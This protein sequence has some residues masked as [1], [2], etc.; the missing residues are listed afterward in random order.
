MVP[1]AP[2]FPISLTIAPN[3][4]ADVKD[5]CLW[6]NKTGAVIETWTNG[7]AT[8]FWEVEN[9]VRSGP[10]CT[11]VFGN[12][13]QQSGRGFHIDPPNPGGHGPIN[14]EGTLQLLSSSKLL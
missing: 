7:W 8:T 3:V 11:F 10:N 13:G 5:P 12:G 6:Q 2:L 1:G 4:L 14:T 9:I